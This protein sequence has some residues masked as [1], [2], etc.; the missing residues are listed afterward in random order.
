[1]NQKL[2]QKVLERAN[3]LCEYCRYPESEAAIR[4]HIDHVTARQHGGSDDEENLCFCCAVCNRYKGPNLSSVDPE[5]QAVTTLYNPRKQ[6]W[7]EHFTSDKERIIGL[8]PEER[9]TVFLLCLNDEDR[10]V[11]RQF[12]SW[13]DFQADT[14]NLEKSCIPLKRNTL[15]FF[16]FT[17]C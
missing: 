8:T 5:T 3:G 15:Y 9:T 12:L 2:R 10:L 13:Y 14:R 7:T 11:E 6:I 4:H 17:Y 1:M 16:Q